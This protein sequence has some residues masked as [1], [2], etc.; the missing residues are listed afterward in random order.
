M[1]VVLNRPSETEVAEVATELDGR[2]GVRAGVHRRPGPAAGA[3]RARR[4]QRPR[5]GRVDRR[6]RRRLRGRRDELHPARR[7][8][9]AGGASTPAT[10]AGERDSSRPRSTRR[11]GSSSRRCR[12]SSSR[13]EPENLWHDGP[14]PQGRPV[15]PALADARRSIAELRRGMEGRVCVI[16]AGSSGIASCQVLHARGI[17]FD[18]FEIGSEVGGNWRY[19]ERQPDVLGLPLAAHQHLAADDGLRDLSDA[20]G[21]PRLPEPLADRAVLRRLRRPLRL[22][23][24]DP[25]P[26]R[27]DR[28][29][30]GGGGRLAGELARAR[31]GRGRRGDLRRGLRGQRP[32]LGRALAR[33]A[34]PGAGALR[35]RADP[36]PRLQ[37][38]RRA[39]GQ[40]GA[41]PG[42][43]QLGHR[44]RGRV[45]ARSPSARCWRC[46][47]GPGSCPS[48]STASR[49][50]SSATGS[51]AACPWRDE[52]DVPAGAEDGGRRADGLRAAR[53]RPQAGRGAPDDLCRAAAA[54]RPRRHRREA[55]HRRVRGR[56]HGALR[57]R[58]GRGGRPGDLLHRLQDQ[59]PVPRSGADRGP[60]Q[61]D[62]ALP[63]GGQPRA[64]G[65]VLHRPAAA[66]GGDHADRRGAVGVD[67]R[68]ARG[69]RRA[70]VAGDDAPRDRPRPRGDGK[71][72]RGLQAAHD[73]G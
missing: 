26:D 14:R 50:T 61:R 3:G 22:S 6:R 40:A 41:G 66:A 68:R 11:R 52:G 70:A 64:A 42:D 32:P 49:P 21:L 7:R 57:R 54:D 44:R 17:E 43:R 56:A 69:P 37:D 29:R 46:G 35:G 34:V 47:A 16:G 58:L 5:G 2:G 1:G 73:P 19:D 36:R 23:R 8:P 55:E 15:R 9:C 53:A 39:R 71:A 65:A 63:P 30:A 31:L 24:P 20:G 48:T 12:R 13:R 4:V 60:R 33:A 62:P 38:P 67:R 59:L 45:V 18:C 28:R 10:R 51:P 27:G 72:L 25:L